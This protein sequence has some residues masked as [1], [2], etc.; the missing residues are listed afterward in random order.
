MEGMTWEIEDGPRFVTVRTAGTFGVAD[1]EAMVRDITSRDFW[2]PDRDVLF[3]HRAL[4][5]AGT[6]YDTM[7]RVAQ[8][9]RAFD[10]L[11]GRGRAA[12]LM[13][14]MADYGVGRIFDGISS[15]VVEARMQ[16]FVD[17]GAARAWLNEVEAG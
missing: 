4:S 15:G 10:Q 6:G 3:D 11:I 16:A 8:T 1:H 7:A 13:A 9:H 12:M 5:W 2:K 14:N 17:E